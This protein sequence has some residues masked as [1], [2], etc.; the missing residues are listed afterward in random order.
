MILGLC[1]PGHVALAIQEAAVALGGASKISGAPSDDLF[2]EALGHRAIVYA[3]VPRLL[4]AESAKQSAERMRRVVRG[5]HAPGVEHVVT[6]IPAGARFDEEEEVLKKDGVAY[7]I[8][9]C[10]PLV[11]ELADATN[12]HTARS[13]WLPRG[14]MVEL[15]SRAVLSR[16][17]RDAIAEDTFCGATVA[18]EA[19]RVEIA[20]AMRR[21]AGIAGAAVRVHVTSPGVSYAMRKLYSWMGLA[22]PDVEALCDRLGRRSST[23]PPAGS[24]A[25]MLS[26]P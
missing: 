2:S 12:L 9:R 5:A 20:E 13:V 26:A 25:A 15:C 7:T 18:V 11:D 14:H 24:A 3:P 6:V 4:D 8:L 17:I 19:E 22:P 21:A 1:L 10:G 16:T 23:T